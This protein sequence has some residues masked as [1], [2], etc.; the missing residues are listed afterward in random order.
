MAYGKKLKY[1]KIMEISMGEY[2]VFI[3]ICR[4]GEKL[5]VGLHLSNCSNTNA[6]I[7]QNGSKWYAPIQ[8]AKNLLSAA[9]DRHDLLNLRSLKSRTHLNYNM[10]YKYR[11]SKLKLKPPNPERQRHL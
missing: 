6:W 1:Q 4:Y 3:S 11:R 8:Q 10:N 2:R 7:D 5:C 9:L